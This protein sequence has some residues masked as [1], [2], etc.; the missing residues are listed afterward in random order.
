MP[1][2]VASSGCAAITSAGFDPEELETTGADSLPP[3]SKT[4]GGGADD[5]PKSGTRPGRGELAREAG[6]TGGV[7]RTDA[8]TTLERRSVDNV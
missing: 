4:P 7:A 1:P 5:F 2:D 8:F 3:A 6:A